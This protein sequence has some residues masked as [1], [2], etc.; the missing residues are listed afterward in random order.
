MS[1]TWLKDIRKNKNLTQSQ[2]AQKCSMSESFY[3]QIEN[4]KRNPSVDNAKTLAAF[5]MFDWTKLFYKEK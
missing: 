1:R 2:I 5:L 4:D 3:N